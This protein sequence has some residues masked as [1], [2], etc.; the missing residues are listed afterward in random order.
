MQRDKWN[1]ILFLLHLE[2]LDMDCYFQSLISFLCSTDSIYVR[3]YEKRMDLLRAVIVGPQG[4]PYHD[5]LFVFDAF[6]PDAYPDKPPVRICSIVLII[7][8]CILL[9]RF[10]F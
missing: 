10:V 7:V 1:G 8:L 5:G 4:T 2:A 6:F 3:V 9:N